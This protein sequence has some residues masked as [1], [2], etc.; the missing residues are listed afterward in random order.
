MPT[1]TP[2]IPQHSRQ[3]KG[4]LI[5][6]ID[7]HPIC[8]AACDP[9]QS[10]CPSQFGKAQKEKEQESNAPHPQSAIG[11]P[12]ADTA[13]MDVGRQR[14]GKRCWQKNRVACRG[15]KLMPMVAQG[16]MRAECSCANQNV[17]FQPQQSKLLPPPQ[18]Q[19]QGM[20]SGSHRPIIGTDHINRA[21]GKLIRLPTP[22]ISLAQS[23]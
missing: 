8:C 6:P 17:R 12:N 9:A 13:K 11:H 20:C 5:D 15:T 21:M 1:S 18:S 19:C 7:I 14:I 16:A 3:C 2:A 22:K 4:S 10:P 23:R